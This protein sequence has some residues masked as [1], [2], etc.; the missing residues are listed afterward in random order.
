M[1]G[2]PINGVPWSA[3][4][5]A[6]GGAAIYSAAN[7]EKADPNDPK[8]YSG[9]IVPTLLQMASDLVSYWTSI[10]CLYDRYWTAEPEKV[11]L[12]ICMFHVKRITPNYSVEASKKRV[13]LYE[14]EQDDKVEASAL[15][16]NMRPSVMRTIVDNAVKNPTTYTMEIIVPFQPIGR[17]VTEGVKMIGDI[18]AWIGDLTG[19]KETTAITE[20]IFSSIFSLLKTGNQ[21]AGLVGKLPGM[22]GVSFINMN[23]LEAMAASCRTLCMKMWT[24]YDYK[25]V[26]ITGMTH[27]KE[28][29]K[30]NVFKATLTL[31]EIPVLSITRP[32]TKKP[33]VI[34]RNWAAT[35]VT[36][37]QGALVSPL[38]MLTGVKT[39]SGSDETWTGMIKG[40]LGG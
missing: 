38:I 34:D 22:D 36:A 32:K 20:G 4:L 17:Y 8:N 24:G 1:P 13:I 12:P 6:V 15:A 35:A 5:G 40:A 37:V 28:P 23:S 30:D 33:N 31:Q 10:T 39:A 11:T 14:P 16:D 7:T 21:L 19:S 27:D 3:M 26:M 25:Y 2:G 18:V 9:I 29:D